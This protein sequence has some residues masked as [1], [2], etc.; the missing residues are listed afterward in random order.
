MVKREK[1]L[2]EIIEGYRNTICHRYQ[3]ENIKKT[4][5]LPASIDEATVNQLRE[6]F[7]N[8]MYPAHDKRV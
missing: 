5:D 7:L 8:Y 2:E 6:Y 1:V 3:Y 4:Y